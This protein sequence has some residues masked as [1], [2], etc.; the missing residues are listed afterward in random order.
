MDDD[1][2][3]HGGSQP[4][5][6]LVIGH[7]PHQAEFQDLALAGVAHGQGQGDGHEGVGIEALGVL[8]LDVGPGKG[9][10]K[11]A[12]QV[13]VRDILGPARFGKQ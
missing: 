2:L 9:P 3:G 11:G 4:L 8:D 12:H 10:L 7:V 5:R 13:Q 6:H 1:A